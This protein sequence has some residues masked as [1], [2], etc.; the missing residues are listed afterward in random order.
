MSYSLPVS[1]VPGPGGA[2]WPVTSILIQLV[3]NVCYYRAGLSRILGASWLQRAD[4]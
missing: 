2:L 3:T 1:V 4:H